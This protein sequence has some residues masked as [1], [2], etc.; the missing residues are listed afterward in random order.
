MTLLTIGIRS[1]TLLLVLLAGCAPAAEV[2][3]P[4]GGR[5]GPVDESAVTGRWT[6]DVAGSCF[7]LQGDLVLTS[8]PGGLSGRLVERPVSPTLGP[9]PQQT[10][11]DRQRCAGGRAVP[12]TLALDDVRF[13]GTTLIF[14]GETP[15]EMPSPFR[16]EARATVADGT[17]R[18]TLAISGQL[19][20][21]IRQESA[22]L[23]A[24]RQ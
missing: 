17:M 24:R 15:P 9:D 21:I 7:L 3:T 5:A 19:D 13:D 6:Y 8:G 2:A 14:T 16:L 12:A 23:T 10:R 18:G 20:D 22:T 1:I 4:A 11:R